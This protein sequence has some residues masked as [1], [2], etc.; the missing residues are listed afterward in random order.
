MSMQCN[1]VVRSWFG[2]WMDISD[3]M[4]LKISHIES[5]MFIKLDKSFEPFRKISNIRISRNIEMCFCVKY[6]LIF[7]CDSRQAKRMN[8]MIGWYCCYV[9]DSSASIKRPARLHESLQATTYTETL[10]A[11][12]QSAHVSH[13]QLN[14]YVETK[15]NGVCAYLVLRTHLYIIRM[16][17]AHVESSHQ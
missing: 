17:G 5:E 7:V 8:Y 1:W 4:R 11:C 6:C 13:F 14:T 15:T 16:C 3:S 12:F 2:N 9:T 10:N